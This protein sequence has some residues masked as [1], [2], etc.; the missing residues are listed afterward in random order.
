MQPIIGMLLP[1]G[2]PFSCIPQILAEISHLAVYQVDVN[3]YLPLP[4]IAERISSENDVL[5]SCN[6]G[7]ITGTP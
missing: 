3:S 7:S 2:H 5:S 6:D 4:E 1:V